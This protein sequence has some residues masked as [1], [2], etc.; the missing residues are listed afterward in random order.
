MLIKTTLTPE[1][2]VLLTTR[3]ADAREQYHQLAIGGAARVVVDQ[4]GERVEFT[5]ANKGTLASYIMSLESQLAVVPI[6][7]MMAGPA[8]FIF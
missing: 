8:R 2:R 5:A 6:A 4:N 3:L 7:S 1:Q